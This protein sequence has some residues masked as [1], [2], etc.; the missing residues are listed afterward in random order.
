MINLVEISKII[1]FFFML[2]YIYV[3]VHEMRP[4]MLKGD[5]F[6]ACGVRLRVGEA[7]GGG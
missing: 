5:F 6:L 1:S 2:Y 4:F 3:D 7:F